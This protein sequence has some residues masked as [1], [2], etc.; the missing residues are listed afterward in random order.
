MNGNKDVYIYR[1][2]EKAKSRVFDFKFINQTVYIH[3]WPLL[4][5]VRTIDLVSHT[6]CVVCVRFIQKSTPNNNLFE[7]LFMA[8]L[9]LPELLLEFL[10]EICWEEIVEEILFVFCFD[11]WPWD[12]T[13]ALC[14]NKPTHFLL[15]FGDFKSV[16]Y[17]QAKMKS[18]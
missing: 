12:R 13:L 2:F 11:V 15:D 14:L 8:I 16:H 6:T 9:V 4:P 7:I 1:N 10:P 18:Q 5:S 17:T 3:S